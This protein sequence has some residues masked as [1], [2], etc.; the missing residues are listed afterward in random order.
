MRR[1]LK[2]FWMHPN[3]N[4]CR[5][6]DLFGQDVYHNRTMLPPRE[7]MLG[8]NLCKRTLQRCLCTNLPQFRRYS[9]WP[10]IYGV[11]QYPMRTTW[12]KPETMRN[13]CILQDRAEQYFESCLKAPENQGIGLTGITLSID[14]SWDNAVFGASTSVQTASLRSLVLVRAY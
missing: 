11:S 6:L 1:K 12:Y 13:G 8:S 14:A 2:N 7:T 4:L 10:N 9:V 3:E 5:S